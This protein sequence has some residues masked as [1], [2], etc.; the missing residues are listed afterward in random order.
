MILRVYHAYTH[1]GMDRDF[2]AFL[3][4]VGL[5]LMRKQAGCRDATVGKTRWGGPPH[6]VVVSRWESLDHLKGFV[7]PN[8]QNPVILPEETHMVKEVSVE[9]FEV[10]E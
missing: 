1:S 9:H 2:E 10:L 4:E 3:R 8:Y 5:P 6:F 7:G